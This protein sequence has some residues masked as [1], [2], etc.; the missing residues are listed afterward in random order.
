MDLI[1]TNW[2][3][4]E[5][6]YLCAKAKKEELCSTF[7]GE[8]IKHILELERKLDVSFQMQTALRYGAKHIW[9]LGRGGIFTALWTAAEQLDTGLETELRT[10]PVKQEIIEVCE[11]FDLNPY[12]ML[13]GGS[14]LIIRSNGQEL[15]GKL[16]REGI[17]ASVIGWTVEG[18]DRII[19]DG[20]HIRYLDRPQKE[21]L[22][23]IFQEGWKV[24]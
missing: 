13:S 20:E 6:A 21:E 2:I 10:I 14:L 17:P 22:Y 23:K 24:I 9:Q 1:V 7:P 11:Y 18:N 4:M 16:R 12:Y 8:M 3:A 19:S 5:G 15:A